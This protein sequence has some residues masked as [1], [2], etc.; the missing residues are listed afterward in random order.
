[1]SRLESRALQANTIYESGV[2]VKTNFSRNDGE[3]LTKYGYQLHPI[4]YPLP[5]KREGG[6]GPPPG[7]PLS[8]GRLEGGEM[9]Y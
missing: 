8:G 9:I 1:M 6:L 2:C 7:L 4:P 5:L 3:D